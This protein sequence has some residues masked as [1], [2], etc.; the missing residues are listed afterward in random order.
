[1]LK[2]MWCVPVTHSLLAVLRK[3][4]AARSYGSFTQGPSRSLSGE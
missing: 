1:M 3:R 4:W 2:V